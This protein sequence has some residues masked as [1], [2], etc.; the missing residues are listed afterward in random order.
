M[1]RLTL[2]WLSIALACLAGCAGLRI[3]EQL[4][5]ARGAP[6][7]TVDRASF[8]GENLTGRLLITSDDAGYV[9]I[10]R[11]LSAH[12]IIVVDDVFDCDAGS[13]AAHIQADS[14]ITSP[15][16][17]D[18]LSI[19]PGYWFGADFLLLVY[20]EDIMKKP[21]PECLEALLAVNFE[22]AAPGRNRPQLKVRAHLTPRDGGEPVP[23][24]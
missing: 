3:R 14:V 20:A 19:E 9:V 12:A 8:D 17:E 7:V 1:R 22:A 6:I 5:R 18:L 21:P 23:G 11:R 4:A 10:D 24:P 2:T 13:P 16:P 15:R